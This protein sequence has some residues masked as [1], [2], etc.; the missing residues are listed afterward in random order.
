[1]D[2]QADGAI[3]CGDEGASWSAPQVSAIWNDGPG[4][5]CGGLREALKLDWQGE[6][7]CLFPGIA[8][9]ELG[10]QSVSTAS[11]T[12]ATL[13]PGNLKRP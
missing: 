13:L 4:D 11:K 5:I 8:R 3:G 1:M 6:S 7:R 9:P 10:R 12:K 2:I